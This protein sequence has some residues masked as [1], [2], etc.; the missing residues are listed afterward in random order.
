RQE[1][2]ADQGIRRYARPVL[3]SPSEP[4]AFFSAGCFT[5][6]QVSGEEKV[7]AAFEE[8]KRYEDDRVERRCAKLDAH[9]DALSIDFD[10]E[11]YPHMLTVIVGRRWVIGYGLRLAAMKCGESL[12]MRQAFADVVSAG[13][14]KGMSEGMR[15]GVEHGQAQRSIES[16]EAHDPEVEAKFVAALQALKD[17][18]YPLL[19]QLEGLK[20]API[21]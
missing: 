13:I 10:E 11:L 5:K 12:D 7:K 6:E 20:D 15:H 14:T 3:G 18:K 17:L 21:D 8:F 4:R 19:D 9:M 16:I 1:C 2:W